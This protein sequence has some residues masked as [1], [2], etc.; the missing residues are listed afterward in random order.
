[1]LKK[2]RA[3]LTKTGLSNDE[4][5]QMLDSIEPFAFGASR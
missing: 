5:H 3:E 2:V 4:V 1:M